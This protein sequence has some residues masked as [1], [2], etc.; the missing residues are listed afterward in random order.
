MI[1][2]FTPAA[3]DQSRYYLDQLFGYMNGVL[4]VNSGALTIMGAM[5]KTVNTTALVVGSLVVM[6]TI[7]MGLLRTAQEGEFLGRQWSSFWVPFRTVLGVAALFPT[8]AGYSMLQ[9]VMMW[10]IVQGIGAA[11]TLWTNVLEFI[12]HNN[13]SPYTAVSSTGS[14]VATIQTNVTLPPQ[15]VSLFEGLSCQA[16][17]ARQEPDVYLSSDSSYKPLYYCGASSIGNMKTPN[18][19]DPFCKLSSQ[20]MQNI[21]AATP[22]NG[23]YTYKM[24]PSGV[25]GT[26]T[27]ADPKTYVDSGSNSIS[28]STPVCTYATNTNAA[29]AKMACAAMTQQVAT[30]Q[31]IVS[32]MAEFASNLSQLD[33]D[34]WRNYYGMILLDA[35]G[36]TITTPL[37]TTPAWI[38]N[39]C[40]AANI[41]S[42][43]NSSPLLY[44]PVGT[45]GNIQD[46]TNASTNANQ[47]IYWPY[48]LGP[49]IGLNVNEPN[50]LVL[51]Y[52]ADI[53][54]AAAT[55]ADLSGGSL[56]NANIEGWLVAGTYYYQ[57]ASANNSTASAYMPYFNVS[58]TNPVVS[59]NTSPDISS[60][61]VLWQTASDIMGAITSSTTTS[62]PSSTPPAL[63]VTSSAMS[64][65]SSSIT[66]NFMQELTGGSRVV[67]NPVV[68]AQSFGENL[69]ITAQVT[70]PIM[71]IA[72]IVAL[73]IGDVNIMGLGTGLTGNPAGPGT[74]FVIM[75][76]WAL[77][78]FFAGW[79]FTFGGMLAIYLP[80]IPYI[81][82]TFGVIGWLIAVIEAMVAAPFV[83]I[84]ILSPTGHD[85]LGRSEPA[86][87]IMA[88][89]CLRPS[90]MIFGMIAGMVLAP[91]VVTMVNAG[92]NIV[93]GSIYGSSHSPGPVELI[94]MLTAY[95]SLIV[96]SMNKCFALIYL[97]PERVLPWIGG[98]AISYGEGE[99][100]GQVKGAVE[101]AA[102]QVKSG[103][104]STGKAGITYGQKK[105]EQK[106]AAAAKANKDKGSAG[107]AGISSKT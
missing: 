41:K 53:S 52:L 18:T 2:L 15:M 9:I 80:L 31:A 58:T 8:A 6:H 98:Q 76:L 11:D 86:I 48:G 72:A 100:L 73:T 81:I 88:N 56:A 45:V 60:N 82:F 49:I 39:Y 7:V 44:S 79:C 92:F 29:I 55:G 103:A 96:T 51:K 20:D 34:Y 62:T 16:T 63:Q 84:G 42:C 10:M 50:V 102:G 89:T 54:G 17:L 68:D 21:T 83:A 25:C 69:L 64:S 77:Y 40:Q 24:G 78:M 46:M 67:T 5:F 38:S 101:G 90:L 33:L 47:K 13:G 106:K 65:A 36:K 61:R 27:F 105:G 28:G 12:A 93:I 87:M 94:L 66:D 14:P 19:T 75:I 57:I 74:T 26:L 3:N 70:Y 37:A 4:P 43:T 95:A 99:S 30:L 107:G 97:I 71:L 104:E 22:A 85:F 1:S 32:T 59:Q 35:S 23:V 91:A